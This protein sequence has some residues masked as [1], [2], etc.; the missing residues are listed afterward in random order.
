[1]RQRRDQWFQRQDIGTH[2]IKAAKREKK[3]KSED[4]LRDQ[5]DSMKH[6]N[7][8]IGA[9]EEE[10]GSENIFEEIMTEKLA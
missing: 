3:N 7:I 1:M 5:W 8:Y 6:A 9:W 4:D 10:K 2:Q